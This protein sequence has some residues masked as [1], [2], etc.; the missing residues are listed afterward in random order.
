MRVTPHRDARPMQIFALLF[1]LAFSAF[2]AEPRTVSTFES[3]GVYWTPPGDPGAG[4]CAMQFRKAGESAWREAL[5]LWF[6]ARNHECRGSVVQLEPGT[7]YELQLGGARFA[8][9]TW[10][11][12]FPIAR[13]VKVKSGTYQLNISEGGRAQ[14]YV[15]YTGDDVTLDGADTTQHNIAISAPYVIV[16]GFT[17]KGARQD[18]IRL[19]PGAH[20]VV[21]EDN[22][23]SEW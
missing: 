10:S 11:E 21:I 2:A 3:I 19:L 7:Q 9:S 8:A 20:D 12:R 15:L 23:I 13:T 4:G 5:P 22:D 6:D 18:A 1:L 14:G 16:R 17:L